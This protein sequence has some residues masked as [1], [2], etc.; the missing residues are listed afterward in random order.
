MVLLHSD[1]MILSL[2]IKPQGLHCATFKSQVRGQSFL[3]CCSPSLE[4]T[5]N[6][7]ETRSMPL[8]KRK[9]KTFLFSSELQN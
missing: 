6:G 3:C 2:V 7:T 9:L 5:A 8:F 4:Q 1:I